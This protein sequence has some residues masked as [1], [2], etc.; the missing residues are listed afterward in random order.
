MGWSPCALLALW[1]RRSTFPCHVFSPHRYLFSPTWTSF[2]SHV[3]CSPVPLFPVSRTRSSVPF[4]VLAQPPVPVYRS[5][6]PSTVFC[7]PFQPP[8]FITCLQFCSPV[9]SFQRCNAS[10]PETMPLP[11]SSYCTC[12]FPETD[13]YRY[14]RRLCGGSIVLPAEERATAQ[15][16]LID[17]SISVCSHLPHSFV[18]CIP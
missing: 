1:Q 17:L 13:P 11:N 8:V 7:L 9:P 14:P 4:L 12:F 16:T 18:F 6:T 5:L 2:S 3:P 15:R 10:G